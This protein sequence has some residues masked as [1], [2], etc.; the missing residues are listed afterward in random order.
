MKKKTLVRGL[1]IIG[2]GFVLVLLPFMA[3]DGESATKKP[4]E[5]RLG[6][7][8]PANTPIANHAQRWA[9]KIAKDSGGRLTIRIYPSDTLI[10]ST[11]LWDGIIKGI[12]DIGFSFHRAPAQAPLNQTFSG[13]FLLPGKRISV[14]TYL[15]VW[16]DTYAKFPEV[17]AEW[18]KTKVLWFSC[19]DGWNICTTKPVRTL[20]DMQGLQIR[21]SHKLGAETVAAWGGS[22]VSMP[23]GECAT[24]LR[25][26][27]VDGA[28]VPM[29]GLLSFRLADITSHTTFVYGYV[30]TFW[31]AMSKNSYNRLPRD[32]QKVIDDSIGWGTND[33]L[34]MF[35]ALHDAGFAYAKS[36]KKGYEF[37][38]L[39]PQEL[40]R[41]RE[42]LTPLQQKWAQGLDAKGLPGTKMMEFQQ[43]RLKF[44]TK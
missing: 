43:E 17:R 1:T 6:H 4:V 37:I 25:K 23:M 9:D 34:E 2:V 11:E 15:K 42:L 12:A 40:Q 7:M 38:T 28:Y 21:V 3:A 32:L 24:A 5:L 31:A 10:K 30:P 16:H 44:Y 20:E 19:M 39:T 14:K 13:L 26:G 41:W 35:G 8:F 29:D 18:D 22:P 27:T 36:L 33:G